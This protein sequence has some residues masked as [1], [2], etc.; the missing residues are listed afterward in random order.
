VRTRLI[1]TAAPKN[2]QSRLCNSSL[3]P[4]IAAKEKLRER[5]KGKLMTLPAIFSNGRFRSVVAVI[6]ILGALYAII[7][8]FVLG[9]DD[10]VFKLNSFIVSPL[11]AVTAILATHLWSQMKKGAQSRFLWGGLF[12]GWICW[13]I[14]EALWAG[15]SLTGEDPYP[16]WAD[17]FFLVG[18]V[19]LSFGF[20]SRLRRL[21]RK[22]AITHQLVIGL[23]SLFV[24]SVTTFFILIPILQEYDPA[25]IQE[26]LLGLFYP[27]AD[28]FLLLLVLNLLFTY[29]PGDYGLGW[30]LILVGFITVT[31][32]D[33]F[34]AYS[35]WNGLYYPDGQANLLSTLT[36]DVLYSASYVLWAL[37]IYALYLLLRE[38]RTF[39]IDF[40]PR[41]T[42]NA[43]IFLFTNR[44]EM[45]IEASQNYFDLFPSQDPCG[46]SLAGAL[47]L[48]GKE[49]LTIHSKLERDRKLTDYPVLLQNASGISKKG[50]LCG[51]SIASRPHE[52][53]GSIVV[54]RILLIMLAS[55]ILLAG[56]AAEPPIPKEL[57]LYNWVEYM[58][59]SVMD[60]FKKEHGITIKYVAYESQKEVP[61]SIKAGNV[62]DLVVL[63]PE[64]IPELAEK[65]LLKPIDY[66][67]VP[68]FKYV[69]ANF[70][71]LAFDPGNKYSIPFHWGT[72]GFLVRTD[73]V[74]RPI[75]R[76]RDLWDPA[77]AGKLGIW[78]ISRSMIPI[79][80]K[81]LGYSAHSENPAE[82][83]KVRQ[84]LLELKPNAV[85]V[86]NMNSTVVPLL[87][88][89]EVEIAFGWAYDAMVAQESNLPI[90]YSIPQEG[91]ILWTDHFFIPANAN[92]PRGAEFFLNFILQPEIAAQIVNESYYPMAV[93][94]REQYVLPEILHNPVI[95]PDN[96]QLQNA[97]I[98]LPIHPDRKWIFDE[99]W[100]DFT[101]GD[102]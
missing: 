11:A 49:L 21:P 101:E 67:N 89:G 47:G 69:S 23:I 2:Q 93:D 58:P 12:L 7:N 44:E 97:E 72:T 46:R 51:L 80:L 19:P 94:G 45:I 91:T 18:Y 35:D 77:F 26:S 73:L 71:D 56:C 48:P 76:W 43:H 50:W 75:N 99:I 28:L 36:V 95:F 81:S 85:I 42:T 1:I 22:P 20:I 17:L 87:E 13:A 68:N 38:H 84:K 100:A 79:T 60:A 61:E 74:K 59:Q 57:I 55:N 62:Y 86:S 92:N 96:I 10:F 40:Q 82:L 8:I 6:V 30:R 5:A 102:S 34:F 53:E 25:L 29:G 88:S 54:L 66:R 41:A 63:G 39:T 3:C 16:S 9:G 33:L 52:Y 31:I 32:S 78:P 37:G 65:K 90:E 27:L 70:R 83:E 14:A 4:F 64:F 24:V 15:Y 98:T